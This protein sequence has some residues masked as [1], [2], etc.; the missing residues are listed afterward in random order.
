MLQDKTRWLTVED[1]ATLKCVGGNNI[2]QGLQLKSALMS[3]HHVLISFVRKSC[4]CVQRLGVSDAILL[5]HK[6]L[7]QD[8][9]QDPFEVE[10]E[11]CSSCGDCHGPWVVSRQ[12][13]ARVGQDW[14][15]VS[16]NVNIPAAHITL[17]QFK[18]QMGA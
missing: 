12:A 5:L 11:D 2:A 18:S 1:N 7:V 4:F 17:K 10:G 6:S 14:K 13:E 9:V 16:Q 3:L 8:F 15:S